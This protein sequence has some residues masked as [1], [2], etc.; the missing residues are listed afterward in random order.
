MFKPF[1][2]KRLLN[3]EALPVVFKFELVVLVV[4]IFRHTV[5]RNRIGD[6]ADSAVPFFEI[7]WI[8]RSNSEV[9]RHGF[10]LCLFVPGSG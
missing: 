2:V 10:M 6:L 3:P 7:L 4:A 8:Y 9:N 1:I 5:L